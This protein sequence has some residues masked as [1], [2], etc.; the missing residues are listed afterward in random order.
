MDIVKK[1]KNLTDIK[2]NIDFLRK[3]GLKLE[4][5]C[6]QLKCENLGIY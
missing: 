4:G 3:E 6:G 1:R 2:G 5:K